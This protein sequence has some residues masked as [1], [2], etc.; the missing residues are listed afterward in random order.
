MREEQKY[1]EEI[2]ARVCPR[3]VDGDGKGG[4]LLPRGIECRVKEFFPT[5]LD[6]VSSVRSTSMEPYEAALRGSV[7]GTCVSQSSDGRCALRD[8]VDC[9]LDRYFPLIV[10][11]VEELDPAKR[12]SGSVVG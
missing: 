3:C 8:D 4:C 9:A 12:L 5:V 1:L 2:L 7:C 10:Q 11:A 6:L